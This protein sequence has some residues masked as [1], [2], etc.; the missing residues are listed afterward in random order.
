MC[1]RDR[2]SYSQNAYVYISILSAN[3]VP[4]L[5]TDETLLSLNENTSIDITVNMNDVDGDQLELNVLQNPINGSITNWDPN[6]G[7]FTYVPNS[8]FIGLDNITLFAQEID[9]DDNLKSSILSMDLNVLDVND[10]PVSFN[11]GITTV[12]Y[13]HLTLPTICSV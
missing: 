5:S 3:D 6:N 9:T 8:Y 12:S 11:Q 13:T 7:T 1:I 2:N 4:T 10:P